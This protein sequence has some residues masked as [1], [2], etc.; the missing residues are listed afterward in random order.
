MRPIIVVLLVVLASAAYA[1]GQ[2]VVVVVDSVKTVNT[3][4]P[5]KWSNAASLVQA[6]LH[7][8]APAVG[9]RYG[10]AIGDRAN[11]PAVRAEKALAYDPDFDPASAPPTG[12][13]KVG[14]AVLSVTVLRCTFETTRESQSH[15]C[16]RYRTSTS[17]M[18]GTITV[19]L[20]GTVT[21]AS[22][23]TVISSGEAKEFSTGLIYENVSASGGWYQNNRSVN[24]GEVKADM[25]DNAVDRA[26]CKLLEQLLPCIPGRLMPLPQ[27]QPAVPATQPT[28]TSE[29]PKNEGNVHPAAE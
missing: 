16:G 14:R 27:K 23:Y 6:R 11:M 5:G 4:Y 2:T 1:Q 19:W 24:V 15:G 18:T 25:M 20:Q 13:G 8:L 26:V 28:P 10:V 22:S 7:D 29:V 3:Y 9:S 17:R 21:D 12:Q